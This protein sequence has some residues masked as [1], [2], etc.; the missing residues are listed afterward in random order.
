MVNYVLE[1]LLHRTKPLRSQSQPLI[2]ACI[3]LIGLAGIRCGEGKDRAYSRGSTV[4][5]AY[6][7]GREALNPS[8]DTNAKYLVFLSLMTRDREG[9]LVG[10][11]AQSWEPS[12]DFRE[13]TYHLRTDILWHDGVPVTAHDIAFTIEVMRAAGDP[14]VPEYVRPQVVDPLPIIAR[15]LPALCQTEN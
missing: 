7:C 8:H 4:T 2:L 12:S 9:K 14:V 13:W 5:V 3:C 10:R 15:G 1:H 11:L 6:C